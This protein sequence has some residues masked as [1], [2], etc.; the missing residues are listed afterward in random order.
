MP[1]PLNGVTVFDLASVG[2]GAR[3][4]RI[5][6]DF[7][8]RVIKIGPPP[9]AAAVSI[10]PPPYAYGGNRFCE[11]ACFD[12]KSAHGVSAFLDACAAADVLIE[13]FRPGAMAR[14]GLDAATVRERYPSLIYCSTSGYGATGP[15]SQWAGH[16]IN[17][18]ATSG[19][20]DCS[21]RREG[22]APALP[23]AT[24]ADVA[25]GG[26]Q[27]AMSI[28]AALNG[29]HT[30]GDG[31]TLDVSIADGAFAI[32][33]LYADEFLATGTEPGPGHYVLTG[34][35]ACYDIYACSDG[36]FISLGAIEG[37]FWK[38]LCQI[39]GIDAFA[40]A[41]YLDERQDEIREALRRKFST[42]TRDEW[43]A[44]LGP[45]N[46]CVAPV[47]SVAEAT[48]D[49]HHRVRGCITTATHPEAGSFEQ[50]APIWAGTIDASAGVTLPDPS[51]SAIVDLLGAV[52]YDPDRIRQLETQGVI[53]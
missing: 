30:S 35:Y 33:S 19:F 36:K 15:R 43:A 21:S 37:A 47:L 34:R 16:D 12:L 13:S 48:A 41:Q 24:V 49:A 53:A 52:G 11:R 9:N 25:A 6:S 51:Q 26:M 27:A 31:A 2:P 22:G 3:A 32:M 23:G 8:A 7:G 10:Q 1:R 38:N 20:L 39:L 18:L 29:R 5:L 4:S 50:S 28:L 40:E 14:L 42:K 46:T 44:E 17:Y 45:K